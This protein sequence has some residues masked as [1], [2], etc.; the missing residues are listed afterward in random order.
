MHHSS[1]KRRIG[2]A[3]ALAFAAGTLTAAGALSA[4]SANAI[5]PAHADF[6]AQAKSAGLSSANAK[7]LQTRVDGYLA[8]YHGTQIAANKVSAKGMY[9]TVALPGEKYARTLPDT[10]EVHANDAWQ[11]KCLNGSPVYS[12][13]FC[14]YKGETFQ[15]DVLS[16]Y[17]CGDHAISGWYGNGSWVNDQTQNTVALL[18]SASGGY[19]FYTPGAYSSSY[20]FNWT[21]VDVVHPC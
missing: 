6:T 19:K 14:L 17:T 9:V 15:G 10:S 2:K 21:P 3:A 18:R 16:M 20:S 12:G 7:V 8:R 1:T 5:T 11:D 13:W 4:G